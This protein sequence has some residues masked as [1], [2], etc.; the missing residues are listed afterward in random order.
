MQVVNPLQEVNPLFKISTPIPFGEVQAE[1]VRPAIRRLVDEAQL[2]IEAIASCQEPRTY[3]NTLGALDSVTE[4][5]DYASSVIQ[6]LENVVS[7]PELRQAWN[8]AQPLVSEFYS[9][10]PLLAGLWT[11]LKEYEAT[12]EARAL[13]GVRG[14]FLKKTI[15][16]FRRHGADLEAAGKK[17]LA[18]IDVELSVICT[19]FAQ[20]VLDATA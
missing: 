7:T 4:E 16:S 12:P 11:A 14:R 15:D 6:H 9:R 3:A 17:R 2:R 18:E 13:N 19:R 5:L 1:H 8:E 20:S 10:I